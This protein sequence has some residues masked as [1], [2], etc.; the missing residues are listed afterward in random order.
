MRAAIRKLTLSEW[1]TA[2]GL[3][4]SIASLIASL[5]VL[6]DPAAVPPRLLWLVPYLPYVLISGL[7]VAIAFL[8]STNRTLWRA[9]EN[10]FKYTFNR[11]TVT[12]HSDL[13]KYKFEFEKHF[14]VIAPGAPDRYSGQFYCNNHLENADEMHHYYA[15]NPLRWSDLNVA[16]SLTQVGKDPERQASYGLVIEP[17]TDNANFIPYN[18]L[19]KSRM[20]PEKIEMPVGSRWILRYRY[21]VPASHWGSYL[22]RWLTFFAEKTEIVFEQPLQ[23]DI[24]AGLRVWELKPPDQAPV[25]ISAPI[26]KRIEVDKVRYTVKFPQKRR[27]RY[28]LTWDSKQLLNVPVTA[29]VQ[30]T[31]QLTV[32]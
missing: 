5:F 19:F 8:Y 21:E 10:G 6:V 25:E 28:R 20:R 24:D 32:I 3:L 29:N 11:A 9:I 2:L 30:D 26:Y 27:A 18:I 4:C 13:N 7:C 14:T 12:I 15:S 23:D 16:A 17:A 31:A 22:N 1:L